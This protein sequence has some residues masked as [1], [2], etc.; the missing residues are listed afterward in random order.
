MSSLVCPLSFLRVASLPYFPQAFSLAPERFYYCWLSRGNA[1]SDSINPPDRGKASARMNPVSRERLVPLDVVTD[2]IPPTYRLSTVEDRHPTYSL[3]T[4]ISIHMVGRPP[5]IRKERKVYLFSSTP[6]ARKW[7][8]RFEVICAGINDR[9]P[10]APFSRTLGNRNPEPSASAHSMEAV[11]CWYAYSI[12]ADNAHIS[13]FAA[14]GV[15]P[16]HYT[17]G[18]TPVAF[19]AV[20][21]N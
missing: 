20:A 18:R 17:L 19:F 14:I 3:T 8:W 2:A 4:L 6:A 13:K 16:H 11:S 1:A 12:M 10:S 9:F 7:N 15:P 5:P 21:I